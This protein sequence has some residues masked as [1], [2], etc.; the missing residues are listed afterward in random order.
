[1]KPVI[2]ITH[3]AFDE[4]RRESLKRLMGQLAGSGLDV[5]V[6][7]DQ[8]REGSLWC[9]R[10]AMEQGLRT[11]ATHIVWLPDDAILCDGFGDILR[12]CIAS[13][14]K[15]V[16]DCY[17]TATKHD[18]LDD[19]GW[20]TT[21]DGYVGLGGCMPRD[22]L[23]EHLAW[24][25]AYLEDFLHNGKP[26]ANDLG[27]NMWCM[28]TGRV[29]YKTTRTL[30]QHDASIPSLDGNEHL[31][32]GRTGERFLEPGDQMPDL[33]KAL[34]FTRTYTGNHWMVLQVAYQSAELIERIY[35][36]ERACP[37][38]DRPS[39]CFLTPAYSQPH[40]P[41]LATR[42]AARADLQDHD[43][44]SIEITTNGDSLVTR[45]RHSL[46]HHFLKTPCTH[47]LFWDSDIECQDPSAVREML[48]TG[49]DV[50]GGMYPFRDG[51][52][53]C[54]GNG[55]EA[56]VPTFVDDKRCL[57]VGEIGT[58]FLLVSRKAILAMCERYPETFY[59]SDEPDDNG[60]PRWALFDVAI[61]ARRYMSEDYLFC[62]RWRATGGKVY[63]YTPPRFRHWG[64]HGHTG[65]VLDA[66]AKKPELREAAE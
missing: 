44:E 47:M 24:R 28:A 64:L 12:R 5:Y 32:N 13:N 1:M 40:I 38:S 8:H 17:V 6:V 65:H 2:V 22:L 66:W 27:V 60:T 41:F 19:A 54:V 42:A 30:V 59:V 63:C 35:A 14:P 57:E 52:G 20:Y 18:G 56:G 43:I 62:Q 36:T 15:N 3:A 37:V 58:G 34:R 31:Q 11:D 16:F 23:E 45:G 39:V 46:M 51:S 10:K 50:I 9:W 21:P 55:V 53:R 26:V 49:H 29:V 48:A 7:H 25:D 4:H 33:S 61:V